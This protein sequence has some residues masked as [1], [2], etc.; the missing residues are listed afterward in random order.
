[1]P[2]T[3]SQFLNPFAG[4]TLQELLATILTVV[5]YVLFPIVVLVIIYTGFLFVT[6]QGNPQKIQKARS[7]LVWAVIGALIIL[8]A[9]A[10]SIMIS[11]TVT[12]L[13]P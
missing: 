12:S 5:V 9:Q 6:A 13:K 11:A 3:A 8:G 4:T 2:N 7:A 1:M 10:F